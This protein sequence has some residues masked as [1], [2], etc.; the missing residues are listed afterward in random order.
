MTLHAA[1]VYVLGHAAL[2]TLAVAGVGCLFYIG[3]GVRVVVQ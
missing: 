1:F 3:A 2:Y